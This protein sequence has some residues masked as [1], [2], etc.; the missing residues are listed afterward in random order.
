MSDAV[1]QLY[2]SRAYPAMSHPSTDPAVTAVAAKLAGLDI[3]TPTCAS[4]LEIG[5]ASGHNLLPLAARWP[6]SHFVGID[7]SAPAID[8]ARETARLAGLTNVEFI[9]CDL[10]D[11]DP[12]DESFDFIIAHG[13]YSWIAAEA[14]QAL[15][16]F[17]AAHLSH[18]GVAVISYNTL[19]GWSLRRSLVDLASLLAKR[20]AAGEIGQEPEKILA[21]LATAAG[22]HT[23]YARHLTA[24]LHDMFGKGGEVLPFD[25]FSPVNEPST[26]LDFAAHAGS[27]GLRYLGES[28]LQ[29]NF[30][31]SLAPGAE[32]T[33]LPLASDPL[34]LQQAIDLLTNRTFRSSLLCRADAPVQTR[35]TTATALHF[36]VRC[37]HRFDGSRVIDRAGNE[38]VQ[39]E[40]PVAL[41]FFSALA[42]TSPQSVP[43]QE[44]L[45]IMAGRL[46]DQFDPTNSLPMI[47]R[48]VVD[49][50]RQNLI[51]LRY[52][53]VRFDPEPPAFPDLG[54]L[55]LMAARKRQPL[56][57][58][59]HVPCSFEDDRQQIAVAMDGSRSIDELSALAASIMPQLDFHAWLG[60]LA[61]RGM[62]C[63]EGS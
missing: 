22:T 37:P 20:P 61:G 18:E 49:S 47:A 56:V 27:C 26:F 31:A 53:A 54:P 11:H 3:P 14:R 32:Q 5:C 42:S 33:L 23:P 17:C 51:S 43:M 52:E 59:H 48:M 6:E 57:D 46:G 30:P 41:A 12:G 24:V 28:E 1:H 10:R 35:I 7:L 40:H 62:F 44:I 2:Q 34:V 55:R 60:H 4:V 58:I 21:F 38:L 13:V 8:S 16:E 25:E 9:A 15:L 36:A 45:E 63:R 19:P 29:E 39:L 50:A